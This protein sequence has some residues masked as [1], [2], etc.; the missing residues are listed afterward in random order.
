MKRKNKM[1]NGFS[2]LTVLLLS[3]GLS[4]TAFAA[5][6]SAAFTDG[7]LMVYEPG[8]VYTD[9]GLFDGFKA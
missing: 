5:D 4:A 7:K 3:M 2:L 8:S 6:S 9:T 1:K